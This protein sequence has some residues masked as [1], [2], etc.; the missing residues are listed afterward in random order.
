MVQG[1]WCGKAL[2][3]L[4][5]LTNLVNEGR[6][7]VI[8]LWCKVSWC[9]EPAVVVIVVK[10]P[11]LAIPS[12]HQHGGALIWDLRDKVPG[13]QGISTVKVENWVE[14]SESAFQSGGHHD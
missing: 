4:N 1:E 10:A 13:H 14:A 7:I 3:T 2:S 12:C 11:P 9:G 8:K 5:R 6:R